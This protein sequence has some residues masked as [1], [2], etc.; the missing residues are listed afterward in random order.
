MEKKLDEV[1]IQIYEIKADLREHMRRT[2]GVEEQ[3][4]VLKD[5]FDPI[6]KTYIGVKWSVGAVVITL[7][8][9]STILKMFGGL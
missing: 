9:V 3:I 1:L 4:R 5:E 7:T 2:D 6:R 8:L